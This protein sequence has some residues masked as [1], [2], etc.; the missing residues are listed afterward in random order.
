[1]WKICVNNLFCFCFFFQ[2]YNTVVSV[3][4]CDNTFNLVV[5]IRT[6]AYMYEFM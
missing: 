6:G 3:G 5:V 1:M 2:V 4:D